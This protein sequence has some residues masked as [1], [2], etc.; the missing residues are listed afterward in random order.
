MT[1]I[2]IVITIG[3]MSI[4]IITFILDTTIALTT[5]I[6]TVIA[7]LN[8]PQYRHMYLLIVVSTVIVKTKIFT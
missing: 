1:V 6:V 2:T 5:Y 4:T 7:I 3:S 8:N